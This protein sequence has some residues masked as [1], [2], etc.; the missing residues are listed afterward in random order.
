[1]SGLHEQ[2]FNTSNISELAVSLRPSLANTF[3]IHLERALLLLEHPPD[4]F[5]TELYSLGVQCLTQPSQASTHP[6]FA[7]HR[8]SS[9]FFLN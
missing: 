8:I 9:C 3:A 7:G 5:M 1:M 2:L 4:D 6:F